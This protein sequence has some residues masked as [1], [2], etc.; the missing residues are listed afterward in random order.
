MNISD[1]WKQAQFVLSPGIMVV[2]CLAAS[3]IL[4]LQVAGSRTSTVHESA[5]AC[6][7]ADMVAEGERVTA[8]LSCVTTSGVVR[9]STHQGTV[10]LRLLQTGSQRLTCDLYVAGNVGNCVVPEPRT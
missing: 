9:T 3:L 4:F 7:V 10:V 1:S 2:L 6:T 5:V 8:K